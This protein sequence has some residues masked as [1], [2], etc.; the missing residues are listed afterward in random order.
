MSYMAWINM[1]INMATTHSI[2]IWMNDAWRGHCPLSLPFLLPLSIRSSSF[3]PIHLT[4]VSPEID[5]CFWS[6]MLMV[7]A[8]VILPSQAV[9]DLGS[10]KLFNPPSEWS[11]IFF[12]CTVVVVARILV[13]CQAVCHLDKAWL[14][15]L[16]FNLVS[17]VYESGLGGL[18]LRS[19]SSGVIQLVR[20]SA[21]MRYCWRYRWL[22]NPEEVSEFC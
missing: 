22:L 2:I 7:L 21:F 1:L 6:F 18:L 16:P 3:S 5:K 4:S 20:L 10:L 8:W 12:H 15:D 9:I 14:W 17:T 19:N 11:L 13:L